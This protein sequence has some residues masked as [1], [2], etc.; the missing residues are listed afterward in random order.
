MIV[1]V[2][3]FV[4]IMVLNDFFCRVRFSFKVSTGCQIFYQLFKQASDFDLNI[5]QRVRF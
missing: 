1:N 4:R 2:K 3:V 5:L